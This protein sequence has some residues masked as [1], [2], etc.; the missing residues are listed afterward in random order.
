L[1]IDLQQT[2]SNLF[3]VAGSMAVG[4]ML[5]GAG[6][7]RRRSRWHM[8]LNLEP[9]QRGVRKVPK[10]GRAR[11]WMKEAR[12][13]SPPSWVV[14]LCGRPCGPRNLWSPDY[15]YQGLGWIFTACTAVFL[16][17]YFQ[18]RAVGLPGLLV[19]FAFI[20][21]FRIAERRAQAEV[22][23]NPPGAIGPLQLD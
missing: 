6:Y 3:L 12:L 20:I 8:L 21:G 18:G 17:A 16:L 4:V 23:R 15:L 13:V 2:L 7:R 11:Y 9:D 19:L 10:E 22:M 5:W 14:W 1:D